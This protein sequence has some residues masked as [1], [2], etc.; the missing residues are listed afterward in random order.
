M[1]IFEGTEL[2]NAMPVNEKDRHVPRRH[3]DKRIIRYEVL[4][5]TGDGVE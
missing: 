5:A 2:V 3:P 4:L 1:D